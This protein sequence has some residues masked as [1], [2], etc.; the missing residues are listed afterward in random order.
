M[1]VKTQF[2]KK[3]KFLN[4]PR[5][6]LMT[7]PQICVYVFIVFN[8]LG[9]YFYRGGTY[10]NVNNPGYSFTKNFFS[11]L[12]RF[13]SFSGDANWI[14]FFLFNSCV[15]FS[16]I[17]FVL[18]YLNFYKLFMKDKLNRNLAMAGTCFGILGSLCLV[19]VGLTPADL[20]FDPHDSFATWTF[21]LFFPCTLLYSIA[22]FRSP[23][24]KNSMAFGYLA[25]S[26]FVISYVLV[27]ELG[28]PST[29]SNTALVFQVVSQK[30][31]VFAYIINIFYQTYHIKL[32]YKNMILKLN[33][34]PSNLSK[35]FLNQLSKYSIQMSTRPSRTN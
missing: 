25:W 10:F 32:L 7:L 4:S 1:T 24:L 3:I 8:I 18:F 22:L 28:P 13:V 23:H 5:F 15:I 20:I 30:I 2:L 17:V 26:L 6:S 11:D 35:K 19:G 27:S 9:M 31:I 29:E 12:G 16:G 21:R 33:Q 14:S 34:T